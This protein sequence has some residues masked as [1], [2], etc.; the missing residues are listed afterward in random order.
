MKLLWSFI[1]VIA[2]LGFG[3]ELI[4]F[5]GNDHEA[6]TFI[7]NCLIPLLALFMVSMFNEFQQLLIHY[8]AMDE[9]D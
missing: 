5:L 2:I 7:V 1:G 6:V 9:D 8:H 4:V 3:R